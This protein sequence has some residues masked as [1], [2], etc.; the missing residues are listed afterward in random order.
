MNL[1][2]VAVAALLSA[3]ASG[4]AV[5]LGTIDNMPIALNN[6][7]PAGTFQ[8]VYAF[9]I[10]NPGS[11][12]GDAIAINVGNTYNILGL[13]VTLQDS[14]F[15]I[16]GTDNTPGNGFTFSSLAAGNYALNVLGFANGSSGGWYAGGFIAQTVPE[17]ET[18]A[19]MLAGLAAVGFIAARRRRDD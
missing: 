13:T 14:S 1:K 12:S 16:I 5:S 9:T 7:V 8:D 15:N 6:I 4:Y 17:P 3:S 2:T 19:M 10:A 11:L 18:Y